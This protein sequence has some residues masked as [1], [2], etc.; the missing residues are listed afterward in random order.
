MCEKANLNMLFIDQLK[1]FAHLI[2][3]KKITKEQFIDIVEHSYS[4]ANGKTMLFVESI[5]QSKFNSIR[6]DHNNIVYFNK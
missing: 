3:R 6:R 4:I 2:P 5:K 1:C